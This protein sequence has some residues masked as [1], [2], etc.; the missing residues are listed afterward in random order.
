ML[1]A[2]IKFYV[3]TT[4]NN[5][6][7]LSTLITLNNEPVSKKSI[8]EEALKSY[9]DD[10]IALY[11]YTKD[12]ILYPKTQ[13]NVKYNYEK[14]IN[15]AK[16]VEKALETAV[17]IF[18][19]EKK[20]KNVTLCFSVTP[21]LTKLAETN[22]VNT[23]VNNIE[24]QVEKGSYNTSMRVAFIHKKDYLIGEVEKLI[25]NELMIT[26]FKLDGKSTI[27]ENLDII[28][29]SATVLNPISYLSKIFY[30]AHAKDQSPHGEP[31][32]KLKIIREKTTISVN[33]EVE[34]IAVEMQKKA[35]E[36]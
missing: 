21:N 4:E 27:S 24:K 10:E 8:I 1:I 13:K 11:T 32:T 23:W 2:K 19:E 14:F 5:Q 17:C 18:I 7:T 36:K 20:E 29:N 26:N 3:S 9:N 22:I 6:S 34:C 28:D 15:T 33:P 12:T 31:K 25:K 16:A 35:Y 30:F